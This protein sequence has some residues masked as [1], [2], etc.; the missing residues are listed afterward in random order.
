MKIHA[1]VLNFAPTEN[2]KNMNTPTFIPN[3]RV[4]KDGVYV[5]A[6]KSQEDPLLCNTS[7]RF[8]QQTPNLAKQ[9]SKSTANPLA[10]T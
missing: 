1:T 3:R 4:E 8:F 9:E 2:F 6:K 5:L 10:P 7:G